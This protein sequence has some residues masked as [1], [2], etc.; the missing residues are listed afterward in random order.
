VGLQ[1]CPIS[2]LLPQDDNACA[3][4]FE[5]FIKGT[6]PTEKENLKQSVPVDKNTNK[7]AA[8]SQTDNVEVKEKLIVRDAF[9]PYC[10]DCDH[11]NDPPQFIR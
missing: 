3:P 7:L 5:Y 6:Q 11:Q 1:V 2:G 8:A 4:R 10:I 9:G